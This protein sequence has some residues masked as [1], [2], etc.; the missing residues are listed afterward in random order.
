MFLKNIK[1]GTKIIA[2]VVILSGTMLTIGTI[3]ING[4]RH[5]GI[6]VCGIAEMRSVMCTKTSCFP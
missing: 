3:G 5:S 4:M 2:M 6:T 1:V